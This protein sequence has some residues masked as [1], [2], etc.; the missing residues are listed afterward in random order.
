MCR[1]L[2]GVRPTLVLLQWHVKDHSH[3][4]KCPGGRLHRNMHTPL[5]QRSRSGLTMPLSRNSVGTYPETSSRSLSGNFRP[6][7]SELP[8]PLW[9]D[10]G[11][12][13]WN[14]CT[15]A[16]LHLKKKKRRRG[17]NGRTIAQS[18]RKRG[19]SHHHHYHHHHTIGCIL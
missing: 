19:K 6:Q 2:F 10:P 9:T 15:Q 18:S 11:M 4:A 3:S 13:E 8:E 7:S 14:K 5:T 16:N 1:L 12:K 17:M